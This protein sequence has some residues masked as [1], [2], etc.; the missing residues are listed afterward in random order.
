L[1]GNH[2]LKYQLLDEVFEIGGNYKP[3]ENKLAEARLSDYL[4][5][6][7]NDPQISDAL[8]ML[9]V[10]TKENESND[11]EAS[12]EIAAPI[13][14]RLTAADKWDF[15]DIRIFAAVVDYASTY[16]QTYFLAHDALKRLEEYSYEERYAVIKLS[17]H[18]NTS[19][20]LIRAKYYD[21][22]GLD[23]SD[24]LDSMFS[25]HINAALSIC[26]EGNFPMHKGV[27]MIRKG[28]Y[29]QD[30][31][32]AK[33][34]F[35]VLEK[36]G[37]HEAYEILK[38]EV[39][40][41]KFF[42]DLKMSK[43]QFNT[44]VGGNL[45]E[46]RNARELTMSDLAKAL[47]VSVGSIGLIERGERSLTSYNMHLISEAFG[48]TTDALFQGIKDAIPPTP[49]FRKTQLQKLD[50]HTKGLTEGELGYVIHMV[51]KLHELRAT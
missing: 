23:A 43:K 44:I 8:L 51:K 16:E 31:S 22:D 3:E 26:E 2:L 50:V 38:N 4:K 5:T 25:S 39:S 27:N 48:I 45:R 19:F 40:E 42:I 24:K 37:E 15:Y 36:A 20:R 13:F 11:F 9:K 33:K 32:L 21:T 41:Y 46:E 18:M 49:D 1:E 6:N 28:L 7:G 35:N 34:G 17:I 30:H 29:Y 10:F 14:D 47:G 12:R